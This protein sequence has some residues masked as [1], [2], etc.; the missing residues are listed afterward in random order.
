MREKVLFGSRSSGNVSSLGGLR[1]LKVGEIAGGSEKPL[2]LGLS[3]GGCR[4]RELD[5]KM[6]KEAHCKN[7]FDVLLGQDCNDKESC[8]GLQPFSP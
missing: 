3:N 5:L 1:G 2:S 6:L 7:G 4:L 8:R